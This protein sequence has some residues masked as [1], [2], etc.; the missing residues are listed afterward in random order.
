[1]TKEFLGDRK[2]ALEESFFARENAKLLDQL[3]AE[4]NTHEIREALAKV[5]G[6]KNNEILEKLCALGINADTWT[7]VSIAPLVEIAW[8]DGKIDDR[9]RQAVLSGARANGITS[10]SP[11]YRLLENWLAHR[12]DGRLLEVWG[13]FIV[14]LCAELG[15]SERESLKKQILGRARRVAEATGGFLG[16]GSK[17]SSE[18]EVIL[19][20]LAKAFEI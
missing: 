8:A 9:E 17:V 20:E 16:L 12:P 10:E 19:A 5:S 1:M 7:A 4:K 11:G 13:T 15:E 2:K 14:G 18:E 3:R 6:I